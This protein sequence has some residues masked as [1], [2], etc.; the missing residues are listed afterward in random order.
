MRTC[1]IAGA[2]GG[3]PRLQRIGDRAA[4]ESR[5]EG[6]ATTISEAGTARNA[7]AVVAG[8]VGLRKAGIERRDLFRHARLVFR[9]REPREQACRRPARR[10]C[11]RD[12]L[13][14]QAA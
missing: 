2:C 9:A 14:R 5:S 12:R 8:D 10:S 1:R 13:V 11:T 7:T 4:V 6:P 3:R